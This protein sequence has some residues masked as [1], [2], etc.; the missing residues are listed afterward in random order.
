MTKGRPFSIYCII[1]F[2]DA[3]ARKNS[4]ILLQR[5]MF[6]SQKW[7]QISLL[8]FQKPSDGYPI[9]S[10]TLSGVITIASPNLQKS[11]PP[12]KPGA[13]VSPRR[14]SYRPA[15]QEALKNLPLASFALQPVNGRCLSKI[16]FLDNSKVVD[17]FS[18]RSMLEAKAFFLS[19]AELGVLISLKHTKENT[20]SR[21]MTCYPCYAAP[22]FF[23]LLFCVDRF[24]T[25]GGMG[26]PTS[27]IPM[28]CSNSN[29]SMNCL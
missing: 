13:Y 6:L 8:A 4:H 14:A 19:P 17:L 29:V 28:C 15:S 27:V 12:A 7:Q 23:L 3:E 24:L 18:L 2:L 9:S 5:G 20:D 1:L 16:N 26:I 25:F 10:V 11:W 21:S 22:L